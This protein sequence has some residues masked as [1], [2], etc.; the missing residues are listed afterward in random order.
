LRNSQKKI[1]LTGT[2]GLIGKQLCLELI[3]AGY[4]VIGIDKVTSNFTNENFFE[5]IFDMKDI[6]SYSILKEKILQK[7]NSVYSLINLAAYNPSVE[8]GL[9]EF[10][11]SNLDLSTWDEEIRINMTSPLFLIK[12]LET[13][14]FK[15]VSLG[16][17]PRVINVVSTYGLVPPN[18]SIYKSLS[19]EQIFKPIGYPVSKA[20]LNMI[21]KY[22]AT[23]PPYREI[24]FNS[25]AP[26]GVFNNQPEEFVA[27]YSKMT[28]VGRMAEVREI[29]SVFLY[30]LSDESTY[31][32]GQVFAIDGGWTTW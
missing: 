24:R 21:T 8:S 26:G 32:H 2:S 16:R 22:L 29:T 30:L 7:T 14:L 27:S 10:S 18:Q 4:F 1:I 12:E 9:P 5:I 17:N 28:P 20:G 31:I 6:S 23:Y 11:I 25:V 15:E 19:D 3:D 13:L